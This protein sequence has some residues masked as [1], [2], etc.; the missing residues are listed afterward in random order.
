MYKVRKAERNGDT[1]R[2][3]YTMQRYIKH[4]KV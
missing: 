3:R 1:E 2:K 4:L